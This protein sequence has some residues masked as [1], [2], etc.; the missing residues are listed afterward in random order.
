MAEY[1]IVS[2]HGVTFH[3]LKHL[4]A[5]DPDEVFHLIQPFF[6]Y[7]SEICAQQKPA[8]E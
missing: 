7:M 1:V 2:T 5:A 3:S 8:C 6:P 4:V